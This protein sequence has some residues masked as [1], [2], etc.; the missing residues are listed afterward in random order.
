MRYTISAICYT[1]EKSKNHN[2]IWAFLIG[3]TA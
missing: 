3:K 1:A 2:T